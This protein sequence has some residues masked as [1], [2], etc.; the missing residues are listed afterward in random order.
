MIIQVDAIYFLLF[1]IVMMFNMLAIAFFAN[2]YL[3]NK[4]AIKREIED[5]INYSSEYIKESLEEHSD[6]QIEIYNEYAEHAK[7]LA[8]E[9]EDVR[10]KQ[11]QNIENMQRVHSVIDRKIYNVVAKIEELEEKINN[12]I[13]ERDGKIN[14]KNKEIKKLKERIEKFKK[15]IGIVDE[16]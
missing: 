14:R 3:N 8:Q 15:Q 2:K 1:A 9:F 5:I 11:Y 12:E 4:E 7:E 13:I 10:K 6:K 16:D